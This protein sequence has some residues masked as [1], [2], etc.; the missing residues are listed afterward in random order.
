MCD[1]N[2]DDALLA[3]ETGNDGDYD[4]GA[5]D[6]EALLADNFDDQN[7]VSSSNR[8]YYVS[9]DELEEEEL[10]H[11]PEEPEDVELDESASDLV[12]EDANDSF[13]KS[14]NAREKRDTKFVSERI[15]PSNSF[16]NV[17]KSNNYKRGVGRPQPQQ[18]ISNRGPNFNNRGNR[19]RGFRGR[20]RGN[21]GNR[22]EGKKVLIN[23]HFQGN[24]NFNNQARPWNNNANFGHN[25]GKPQFWNQQRMPQPQHM[26]PQ[27]NQPFHQ[28]Q[29]MHNA[30]NQFHYQQN[31]YQEQNRT[32]H[33]AA[34]HQQPSQK[35]PVHQRLGNQQQTIDL[36]QN[37]PYIEQHQ[38]Q[39][40]PFYQPPLPQQHIFQSPPLNHP[41]TQP[42]TMF[43]QQPQQSYNQPPPNQTYVINNQQPQSLSM[44]NQQGG[45]Y[46]AMNIPPPTPSPFAQQQQF[47]SP[48][49]GY[50][51]TSTP[52]Y[53]QQQQQQQHNVFVQHQSQ[54][55][56]EFQAPSAQAQMPIHGPDQFQQQQQQQGYQQQVVYQPQH[57]QQLLSQDY[58]PDYQPPINQQQHQF[59]PPNT[60]IQ[61]Q[62]PQPQ[63]NQTQFQSERRVFSS[64]PTAQT[65]LGPPTNARQHPQSLPPRAAQPP[66]NLRSNRGT[67]HSTR[68][69]LVSPGKRRFPTMA[70]DGVA[71]HRRRRTD[72]VNVHEV[73]T[74]DSTTTLH[75]SAN[76]STR[77]GS[78]EHVQVVEAVNNLAEIEEDEE[79]RVYRQ[80]IEHQKHIREKILAQKEERRKQAARK[81]LAEKDLANLAPPSAIVAT[82]NQIKTIVTQPKP[83]NISTNLTK[84]RVVNVNTNN[85]NTTLSNRIITQTAT[86]LVAA[87]PANSAD[88][89]E[90]SSFLTN[91]RIIAKDQS[92]PDTTI[93]VVS[94]LAAGTT[95]V[96]LRKLCQGVGDV[97][98]FEMS[99]SERQATIQ[100]KSI[101]SAHAFFK[102]YQRFM[103]DLSMVTV[104][105]KTEKK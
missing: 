71:D 8:N 52:A 94:N 79:T 32:I 35:A 43:V 66:H 96:K 83:Q 105:L 10:D 99:P 103:V 102:K 68:G 92:L 97:Q 18:N 81:N 90:I 78:V 87:A 2:I 4:I 33:V 19:G 30:N 60:Y 62:Q 72:L 37:Q 5:E 23:P 82:Q 29:H 95:E 91:R 64:R 15:L 45:G 59:N 93:V 84:R 53:E 28:H 31:D 89:S 77:I 47:S 46:T 25:S 76:I 49:P 9:R 63:I 26:Q 12:D 7:L 42:N 11:E 54:G 67:S 51:L 14:S 58:Q 80:K 41:Q 73:P 104:V 98:K 86:Q 13:N 101:A 69:G 6:E 21:I 24:A 36:T 65:R 39:P 50:Q 16:D 3:D 75:S 48:P 57:H 85:T 44:H 70:M 100:F 22:P 27:Q 20:G 61:Q 34:S 17:Q 88:K 55:G 74:V 40:Q 1:Q 56:F 38:Q